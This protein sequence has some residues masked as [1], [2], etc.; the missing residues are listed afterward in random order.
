[1]DNFQPD[2]H[3]LICKVLCIFLLA[4]SGRDGNIFDCY[5]HSEGKPGEKLSQVDIYERKCVLFSS[6]QTLARNYLQFLG[7][8]NF[9]LEI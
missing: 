4:R 6:V 5:G 9:S 1:M 8:D 2:G 3:V 7:P